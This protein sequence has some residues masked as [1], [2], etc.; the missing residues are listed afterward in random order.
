MPL[1]TARHSSGVAPFAAPEPFVAVAADGKTPIYGIIMKPAE[2][3]PAKRYPV[4]DSM[5]AGPQSIY[6]PKT[7][8]GELIGPYGR[9]LAELGFVVVMVDGRGLPLRSRA[10]QD[11]SYGRLQ[12]A[13]FLDD[14][15]AALR[16]LAQTRPWMSMDRVGAFGLSAGGY[17]VVRAMLDHPDFYRVGV[18]TSPY[19]PLLNDRT[20]Q[21]RYQGSGERAAILPAAL[22]AGAERLRGD[23]LVMH[24]D[25]DDVASPSGTLRLADALIRANKQFEMLIVPNTDHQLAVQP[26]A[27]RRQWDFFVRHLLGAEPPAD[28]SFAPGSRP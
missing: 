21:E 7:Y 17:A 26:Y 6:V 8:G 11:A 14:H 1:A 24:G 9:G 2:F 22:S 25:L 20:W 23:L 4:I 27:I 19:D 5:Y 15:V 13:G 12:T 16:Q 10:Y 3:D 18:A 28:Y